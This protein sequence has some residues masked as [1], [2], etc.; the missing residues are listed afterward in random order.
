VTSP[1]NPKNNLLKSLPDLDRARLAPDLEPCAFPH[2]EIL[3]HPGEAMP[4]VY[5]PDRGVISAVTLLEGGEAVEAFTVGN[6]GFMGTGVFLGQTESTLQAIVQVVGDGHRMKSTAFTEHLAES[7]ALRKA[8]ASYVNVLMSTITQ[9]LACNSLHP[10]EQRCARWLLLTH[11]RVESDTF[12]LTQEFLAQ[13]LGV[14]RA[15]V[16]LAARML[17]QA[18]VIRYRQGTIIVLDRAGLESVACECY[19][20]IRDQLDRYLD[21]ESA[22]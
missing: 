14:R 20:V 12:G 7:A 11:D 13:M 4:Y 17:Q 9:G 16:N 3:Y 8:V 10:I 19:F 22:A 18:G 6:E 2:A 15:S 5:F 21:G 1:A